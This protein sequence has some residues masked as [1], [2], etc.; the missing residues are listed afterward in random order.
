MIQNGNL[1]IV[2]TE[3]SYQIT[4][5]SEEFQ[6]LFIQATLKMSKSNLERPTVTPSKSEATFSKWR[7]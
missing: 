5:F 4:S 6:G 1:I 7:S 2:F 3:K